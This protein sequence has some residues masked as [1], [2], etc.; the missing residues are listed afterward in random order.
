MFKAAALIGGLTLI[1]ASALGKDAVDAVG[2]YQMILVPTSAPGEEPRVLL[3][4]TRDGHLWQWRSIEL[5]ACNLQKESC[6]GVTY[7]GRLTVV[8]EPSDARR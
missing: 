1:S 6:T 8:A 2:R 3:L 7:L 5:V 4:D